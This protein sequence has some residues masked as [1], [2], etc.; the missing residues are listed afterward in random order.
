MY[1]GV[2]AGIL[3]L[4]G[5]A[6][7]ARRRW[8]WAV[9]LLLGVWLCFG[10]RIPVSLWSAIH[11]L[12]VLS[13][14]RV[15][16]RF[17]IG[18][19][20]FLA[21]FAGFGLD[22]LVRLLARGGAARFARPIALTIVGVVLADLLWVNGGSGAGPSRSRRSQHTG[23][24]ISAKCSALPTMTTAGSSTARA[25]RTR[26][27]SAPRGSSPRSSPTS[28]SSKPTNRPWSARTRRSASSR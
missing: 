13:S 2:V 23:A 12:P 21:L 11:E 10:N 28:A 26:A 4:A 8:P 17:R 1:I 16:Q 27:R 5:I 3:A 6:A 15:A 22:A 24:A 20:L 14:M 25:R 18:V 9:A 19:V 7:D